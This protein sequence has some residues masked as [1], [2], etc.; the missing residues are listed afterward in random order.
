MDEP[1]EPTPPP[2]P[3]EYVKGCPLCERSDAEL[4]RVFG[5]FAQ[6]LYGVMRAD[7]RK[8]RQSPQSADVDNGT[9]MDTLKERSQINENN[10]K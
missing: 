4:E 10:N 5:E 6:W 3:V 7:Q 9:S 2:Q 8:K 1:R